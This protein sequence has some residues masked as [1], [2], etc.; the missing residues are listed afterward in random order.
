MSGSTV[1]TVGRRA[2]F[3]IGFAVAAIVLLSWRIPAA[4][5][6][7]GADVRFVALPVGEVAVE[8]AGAIAS[9]RALEPGQ[10]R[11]VG[12]LTLVNVAGGPLTV[13][14]RGLPSTRELD[15]LL[16]VELRS[17][18][19]TLARGPL[20]RLR[21]WSEG[22]VVIQRAGRA[23]IDA[24]AWLPAGVRG[25]YEGRAVDVTLELRATPASQG[26]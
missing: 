20:S 14:V 19:R 6:E 23:D 9:G 17:G 5:G 16:H 25:A 12:R 1:E 18:D 13:R 10:G 4:S 22:S 26:G 21:A 8:P 7:L 3:V 2:A 11:A 15:R 24:R